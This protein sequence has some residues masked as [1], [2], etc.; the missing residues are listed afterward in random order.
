V[1]GST[2]HAGWI[3]LEDVAGLNKVSLVDAAL[4]LH[5]ERPLNGKLNGTLS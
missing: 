1:D 4:R 2:T 3:P 5:R